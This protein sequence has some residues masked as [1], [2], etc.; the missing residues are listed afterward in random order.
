MG[1]KGLQTFMEN[2][3][4]NGA[5][6]VNIKEV[7]EAYR[8]RTDREVVIVVDTL[9]CIQPLYGQLDWICGGQ[10]REYMDVFQ[11][12]IQAFQSIGVKL[13]FFL[14]GP[15]QAWK[16]RTWVE[17]RLQSLKG[18]YEIFDLIGNGE[19]PSNFTGDTFIFPPGTV[20]SS[21]FTIKTENCEFHRT[22]KECDEEIAAY[23]KQHNCFAIL[24]QDTDYIIYD[25][26][27]YYFSSRYLNIDKMTTK[28]Y[29]RRALCRHLKLSLGLLPLFATLVGND[30]IQPNDLVLFHKRICSIVNNSQGSHKLFQ[31]PTLQNIIYKV[32]EFVRHHT[33][34]KHL[35]Q[36]LPMISRRVFG[37]VNKV[38]KLDL[39]VRSYTTNSPT[40]S[41]PLNTKSGWNKIQKHAEMLFR[42]G[43]LESV[44]YAV[45]HELPYESSTAIEDFRQ[46]VLPPS[47]AVYLPLR[48]HMY[49]IILSEKPSVSESH[50]VEEWCMQGE[51]SLDGPTFVSVL[52]P[53]PGSHPGLMALWDENDKSE[54]MLAKKWA[55]VAHAVSNGLDPDEVSSRFLEPWEVNAFIATAVVLPTLSTPVLAKI[56]I[57]KADPRAVQLA[58]I[59]GRGASIIKMLMDVSPWHY[60]DGKLFQTMYQKAKSGKTAIDLCNHQVCF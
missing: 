38:S 59:F 10:V 21:V 53:K 16:R 13:V 1:V 5:Y 4:P 8:K 56:Q 3:C 50:V 36:S 54:E 9:S 23:A 18:V 55:L 30:F 26:P 49:G 7:V 35:N 32:A 45:S 31:K 43:E 2:I 14:D 44:I 57:E 27:Q 15:V 52:S 25:G 46:V 20:A 19:H 12:F 34:E 11:K 28:N 40:V 33:D 47:A 29:D 58:C 48:Q 60:F 17:R 24:G 42:N 39:S 22:V 41:P 6:E 37:N 51:R